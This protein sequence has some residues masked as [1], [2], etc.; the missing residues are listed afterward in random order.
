MQQPFAKFMLQYQS[1]QYTIMVVLCFLTTEI[2]QTEKI[3]NFS[4]TFGIFPTILEFLDF[5]RF[6][7]KS[8]NTEY[9]QP[10]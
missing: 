4:R 2:F 9:Q 8:G 10:I 7:R 6:S 5:S 3:P 1:V